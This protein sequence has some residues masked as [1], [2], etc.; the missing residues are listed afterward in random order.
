MKFNTA[1]QIQ[2]IKQITHHS[3]RNKVNSI[4]R[5]QF[6]LH[7]FEC[8]PKALLHLRVCNISWREVQC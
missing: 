5:N 7:T 3:I 1:P 2:Q 8:Q 4:K 6:P